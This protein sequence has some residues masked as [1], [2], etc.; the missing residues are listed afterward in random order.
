MALKTVG[1]L[2]LMAHA[3]MPLPARRARIPL[4]GA[5]MADIGDEQSLEGGVSTFSSHVRNLARML[6]DLEAPALALI[7]EIGTGTDPAE[8]AALGTAVLDRLL[9]RGVHVVATTHHLAVKTWAYRRDGVTNAACEFDERSLRPTYR[10]VPG[11]AGS[12][13][14]LTMAAQLG[15]DPEVVEEARR[16][17]D[18]SGAEAARA[19]ENVQALAGRLAAREAEITRR[20]R[21]LDEQARAEREKWEKREE[22]RRREWSRRLDELA[23]SYRKQAR[24]MIARLEDARERRRLERE[25]ARRE[26]ELRRRFEEDSRVARSVEPAPPRGSP[27]PVRRS[28]S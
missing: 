1:L 21:E 7:D 9:S 8:G 24:E 3:G 27:P 25:Q 14:G 17:L 19:L 12:S 13:I 4:L 23:R 15:L 2:A 10:L 11:V 28:G 18:P 5:L 20:R 26:R 6:E 16:R 22:A